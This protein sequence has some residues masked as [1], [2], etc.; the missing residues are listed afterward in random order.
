MGTTLTFLP[1]KVLLFSENKEEKCNSSS[2]QYTY[3]WGKSAYSSRESAC[4]PAGRKP[5]THLPAA[6][7]QPC[8][9]LPADIALALKL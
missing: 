4:K 9:R 2:I 1:T 6:D 8:T 3:I 7:A 5:S